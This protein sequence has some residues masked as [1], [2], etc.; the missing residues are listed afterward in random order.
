[1]KRT[2]IAYFF[3]KISLF[4]QMAKFQNGLSLRVFDLFQWFLVQKTSIFCG[5]SKSKKILA[6]A[7]RA[8][9]SGF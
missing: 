1:M 2:K 3:I 5:Y 9:I 7:K 6:R 8:E 4:A